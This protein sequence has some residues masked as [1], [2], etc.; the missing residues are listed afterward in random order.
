MLVGGDAVTACLEW[1]MMAP[2]QLIGVEPV[3]GRA[4]T[5]EKIAVNAVMTG[6]SPDHLPILIAIAEVAAGPVDPA[7]LAYSHAEGRLC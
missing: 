4:V 6:C 2:D 3:R 7:A 5:A 1:A